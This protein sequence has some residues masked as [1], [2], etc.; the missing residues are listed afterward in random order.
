[1]TAA[2]YNIKIE[3]GADWSRIFTLKNKTTGVPF[4]LTGCTARMHI[5]EEINDTEIRDSLTTE[6]GRIVLVNR[7]VDSNLPLGA[8]VLGGI[9]I[10][11]PNAV[12]TAYTD[13]NTGVYQL[14][15]VY[16]S[17]IVERRL[18]GT[19]ELSGEVTR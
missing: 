9:K 10:I 14:E 3:R 1:M 7:P 11:F 17:G 6:N 8:A 13:W 2:K 16:P 15:L 12:S 18:Q 4:D 5:R 19:V